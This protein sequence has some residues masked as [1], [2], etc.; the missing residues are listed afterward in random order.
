MVTSPQH[1]Q[2]SRTPIPETVIGTKYGG[3]TQTSVYVHASGSPLG[4]QRA[5]PGNAAPFATHA[6]YGSRAGS[7][8]PMR[9]AGNR[10]GGATILQARSQAQLFCMAARKNLVSDREHPGSRSMI[11]DLPHR[12][13]KSGSDGEL[14]VHHRNRQILSSLYPDWINQDYATI[15]MQE[16]TTATGQYRTKPSS[17]AIKVQS[18]S[19]LIAENSSKSALTWL[20][21]CSSDW[22][23]VC[24]CGMFGSSCPTHHW[25]QRFA[26]P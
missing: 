2:S 23:S 26:S 25:S 15:N 1:H 20:L 5:R 11:T 13:A 8:W 12:L 3:H 7:A 14:A 18:E 4:S 24:P 9:T 17:R 6:R 10:T 22:W 19:V 16:E 21:H